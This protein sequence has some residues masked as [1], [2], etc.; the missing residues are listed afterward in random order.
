MSFACSFQHTFN[1]TAVYWGN[2]ADDGYGGR[3][4]DDP[5]EIACRWEGRSELFVDDKGREVRS[6][7]I[8]FCAEEI[9]LGGKLFL[10]SLGDLSSG[11]EAD[12]QGVADVL[13]VRKFDKVPD[14]PGDTF[15][16]TVWL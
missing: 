13:E 10:G 4:F 1:H 6:L 12:P 14:V 5:V 8:V 11:E 9:D 2:P 15:L 3:T 16:G 7:A